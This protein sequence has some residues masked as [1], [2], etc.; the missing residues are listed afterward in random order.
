M[1]LTKRTLY[2]K[3]GEYKGHEKD[4]DG[5]CESHIMN[6]DAKSEGCYMN[7]PQQMSLKKKTY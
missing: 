1:V 7:I 2:W 5:L 6:C 3:V 4:K